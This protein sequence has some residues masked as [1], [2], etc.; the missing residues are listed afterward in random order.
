[1][2]QIHKSPNVPQILQQDGN[3]ATTD[4]TNAYQANPVLFT[5]RP[6]VPPRQIEKMSFDSSIY[7]AQSVKAQLIAEQHGKC[8]FCEAF[9]SDNSY[10]DVERFRP[11]KA[12]KKLG[13]RTLTYPGYYWL[14]Y[15]WHN[16]MFSC[17]K[18]NRKYKR[19]DFPLNNEGTRALNHHAAHL[20]R[21]EDTLLI[22]PLEE[23]P[24]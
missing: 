11:K 20:V 5:S 3:T 17:E 21:H 6:D 7:G 10:G 24:S 12:Y 23:D 8:C 13:D 18:C 22:N 4:L 9:F 2:I 15:D 1:M 16:L 19:N 14:A